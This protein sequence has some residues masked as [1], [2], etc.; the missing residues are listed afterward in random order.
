MNLYGL[1]SVK[2]LST[3]Y[4]YASLGNCS[5][6]VSVQST[7]SLDPYAIFVGKFL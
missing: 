1:M 5:G 2:P 7:N 4:S 6:V 3:I